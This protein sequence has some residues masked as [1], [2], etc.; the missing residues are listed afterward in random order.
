MIRNS[1]PKYTVTDAVF[2]RAAG[3]IKKSGVDQTI[4]DAYRHC[5]HDGGRPSTGIKYT[6][7]AVLTALL[8]RSLIGLPYS[9]FGA[10]ETIAAFSSV[11]LAAVG[12]AGQDC[13]V[14]G[15]T[16]AREYKRLHRFWS[17]R[18]TA[19][20]PDFDLPAQRMTNAEFAARIRSRSAE[21]RQRSR[22]AHELLDTVINDLI[23]GSV[24]NPRPA[25]CAGDL[26][27]DETTINTVGPG[28]T[29]GI[30]S[31]HHRGAC[32]CAKFWARE[33]NYTMLEDTTVLKK[34]KGNRSKRNITSF[35]F[36]VGATFITRVAARDALHAEPPVFIGVAV[37]H[38]SSANL[39]GLATALQHA[40]RNGL[41]AR[42]EGQRHRWPL[43]TADM[44]YNGKRGFGE[45]MIA[46][47]YSP[48][49]RYPKSWGVTYPCT[50]P[51]ETPNRPKPGPIQHA[52][53]FY[54]P[55]VAD[56]ITNHR[57]PRSEEM[58]KRTGFSAHDERLRLIYPFLMGH[59]TRPVIADIRHGRPR[60][61]H[62]P[63]KGVKIRLV[64]PAALGTLKCTLKPDSLNTHRALPQAEPAWSAETLACCSNSSVTVTLTPDQLRLAQWELI[65]GSWEHTLYYEAARA[66]TEQRFSQLKS[67]FVAGLADLKTGPRRTPMI[68]IAIALAAATANIHTQQHHDPKTSRVESIDVHWRRLTQDLGRPPVRMPRRS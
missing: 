21:D 7:T 44:G 16:A 27:V 2:N 20:D 61:G 4:E 47:G 45:L 58:L 32:S 11:Q 46:T 6:S 60:P 54:C 49:V 24:D 22:T 43:L 15:S 65:P 17:T 18:M 57:T 31:K 10:L 34:S 38:P 35:G 50:N 55:A 28:R 66:L 19:L 40:Q 59:H 36:G 52:G 67:P 39:E 26:V 42:P 5:T 29:V 1:A 62:T 8:V 30:G 53:A 14:I 23:Y 63:P 48:V 3:V 51:D 9:L 13:S 12:M 25:N 33:H 64:C 37:H 41:D 56:R 68:K